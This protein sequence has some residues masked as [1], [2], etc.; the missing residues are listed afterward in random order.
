MDDF[1]AAVGA[2]AMRYA[3][4]S[5]IALTSSYA[6][7]QCSRLL[8][9]VDDKNLQ[10][11]LRVLQKQLD[12]KIK[13][14][15]PAIDLIEFKSGR[16]N[17]FLESAL[18]LAKSLHQQIISLGRRVEG[19]AAVEEHIHNLSENPKTKE[20]DHDALKR[21]IRDIKSL[22]TEIDREIPLLQLAISASGESLSTSL[23]PGISPSRL[24]QASTLLT[25]GD[26]QHAQDPT[27]TVQIGPSFTLSVYMLFLGHASVSSAPKDDKSSPRSSNQK[28]SSK[29]TDQIPVYGLGEHDRRPVWQEAIHKARVRLCRSASKAAID[30]KSFIEDKENASNFEVGP[31]YAY[32]LEI[33][34]D[35]DD[36]RAH[37]GAA[38]AQAY[39][40]VSKA[41][42]REHIPIYQLAKIFYTDTGRMLNIGDGTDGENNPVL[43]L[44]RDIKASQL[45]RPEHEMY[46]DANNATHDDSGSQQE[47]NEDDQADVDRQL[48]GESRKKRLSLISSGN[49]EENYITAFPKHLDPEWIAFEVY[50]E[51]DEQSE[52]S[53]IS[54]LDVDSSNEADG[55]GNSPEKSPSRLRAMDSSLVSQIKNLSVQPTSR[56]TLTLSYSDP[57]LGRPSQDL[58]VDS[59]RKAQDF[60]SRSPFGT[61]TTSLSLIEM[62]IRLAGLQEFQQ[63]SH[64]S[65]P[66]HIL[67]FFLEETSTTGLTGEAMWRARSQT[68]QRVGFDPYTDAAR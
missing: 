56:S 59:A 22:L 67:T 47:V 44:K 29:N 7:N 2:Q 27:R 64:L 51:D 37:E 16:G 40:G 61:I 1:L 45:Q 34:E 28:I 57:S 62:L 43:L 32:H 36:G 53:S 21:V 3:I 23:P 12:G 66:D 17:I 15:S 19:A 55:R 68:K 20:A 39:N 35:L 25:V 26:T 4:R 48:F 13:I 52:T 38:Q 8:K 65:I 10:S 30:D 42:I 5:G 60:V 11:E 41:G 63:A 54:G 31:T 9:A 50:E 6:I 24:L 14:I 33:I 49:V 58:A 46:G 18:P